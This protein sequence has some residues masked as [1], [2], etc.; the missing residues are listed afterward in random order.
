[1]TG[2]TG[3]LKHWRKQAVA[4]LGENKNANIVGV[5]FVARYS[6]GHPPWKFDASVAMNGRFQGNKVSKTVQNLF[7]A[8]AAPRLER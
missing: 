5:L 3:S 2:I 1:M 6:D 7:E 8:M 4:A